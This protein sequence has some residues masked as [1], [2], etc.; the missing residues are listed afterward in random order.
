MSCN[1]F[2][3]VIIP[4]LCRYE[5]FKKCV[6][7]LLRCSG[8]DKTELYIGLDYPLKDS[9]W[10]G[11][12]KI[13]EFVEHIQGFKKVHIIRH[14]SNC[15]VL[16][17]VKS[18]RE[19]VSESYD[20]FIFSEDDNEFSPNFLEYINEGLER[21]K[22]NPAVFEICG[23]N[24]PF[25]DA[26]VES[27]Y[28]YNVFPMRG[29][30]SWGY[31]T[32]IDKM[33]ASKSFVDNSKVKDYLK[34]WR[35]IRKLFKK[36]LHVEVHRMLQRYRIG[37]CGDLLIRIYISMNN[38]YCIFPVKS[39][40]RNNGFDG[41]GINCCVNEIYAKQIIDTDTTFN[42][43][44]FELKDYPE[45]VKLHS[46]IYGRSWYVKRICEFEYIIFRLF[47]INLV[48]EKTRKL[49]KK[50]KLVLKTKKA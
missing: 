11:Y 2:A 41:S 13:S 1:K 7:S 27:S 14:S 20:R 30:S 18:L 34:D 49:R 3:P 19:K 10:D 23:F 16:K 44:D 42:M 35:L 9:H 47:G 45:I 24:F 48:S 36:N 29:F 22:D 8:A 39:K 43:D 26:V 50:F 25:S 37:A 21:F 33:E 31:G 28:P 5:H 32:W 40:V 46:A 38:M 12:K 6:E 17:N 15:G 4:T